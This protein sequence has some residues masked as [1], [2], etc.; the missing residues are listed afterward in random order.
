LFL[1]GRD[2]GG[3]KDWMPMNHTNWLGG[4]HEVKAYLA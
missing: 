3:Q 2:V 4:G 1:T